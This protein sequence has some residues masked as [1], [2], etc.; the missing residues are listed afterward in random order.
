MAYLIPTH[1]HGDL[2]QHV[3]S[4]E[5]TYAL[6]YRIVGADNDVDALLTVD[7]GKPA[8]LTVGGA[9]LVYDAIKL[10]HVECDA[11]DADVT[12]VH[13][14]KQANEEA[15]SDAPQVS[16]STSGGQQHITHSI[17]TIRSYPPEVRDLF[18]NA[19]GVETT[20]KAQIKIHGTDVPIATLKMT[21]SAKIPPPADPFEF[22]RRLARCTGRTNRNIWQ[23]FLP[24]ELLLLGA[25][26]TGKRR[27]KWAL[28]YEFDC[29]EQIT[30]EDNFKIGELGP[31]RKEG[32]AHLWVEWKQGIEVATSEG[33]KMVPIPNA[34]FIE[35][36][37]F[38]FDL[39][40]LGL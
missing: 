25:K 7:T 38:Q 35:Q 20:S 12:Y 30:E 6:G 4:K 29:S 16:F 39:S 14:D 3:I 2:S 22:A 27:E 40:V 5:N 19:I 31:I 9:L 15:Q 21:I 36:V 33:D 10:K 17:R 11:Y 28:D 13:P 18:K 8:T 24:D 32:H 26:L 23:G 1:G 34:V 37:F